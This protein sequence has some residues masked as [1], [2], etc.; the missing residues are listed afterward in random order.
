MKESKRDYDVDAIAK[1]D[2]ILDYIKQ[3][4][5]AYFTNIYMDLDLPKSSTYRLLQSLK[6]HG[7]LSQKENSEF[8]LGIRLF[9][10]GY[11]MSKKIN[12]RTI[13]GEILRE[14]TEKTDLTTHLGIIND[15]YEGIFIEKVDARVYAIR[16]TTVGGKIKMHASAAGKALVAWQN[17]ETR[18]KIFAKMDFAK[19]TENTITSIDQFLN[20][21]EEIKKHGYSIDNSESENFIRGIGVPVFDW[22]QN[23][24]AA[25]SLGGVAAE[26]PPSRVEGMAQLLIKASKKI[27]KQLGGS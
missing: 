20:E 4:D 7:F 8:E 17:E 22:N 12:L 15:E 11:A 25:I 14:L 3:S 19:H 2:K 5:G 23:V 24:V 10:L 1:A 9:E 16:K 26:L 18:Q 13:S 21:L 27:S 6:K